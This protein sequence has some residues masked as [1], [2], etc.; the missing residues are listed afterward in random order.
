M[1]EMLETLAA[2][3]MSDEMRDAMRAFLRT[4]LR[5]SIAGLA[6]ASGW[7]AERAATLADYAVSDPVMALSVVELL[8]A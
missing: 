5:H 6:E 2:P 1:S 8:S 7:S 3:V 4:E